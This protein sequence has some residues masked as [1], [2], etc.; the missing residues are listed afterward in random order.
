VFYHHQHV[1]AYEVIAVF[2]VMMAVIR[3]AQLSKDIKWIV[4][5]LKHSLLF[6][7][8]ALTFSAMAEMKVSTQ[9][10]MHNYKWKHRLLITTVTSDTELNQLQD[11]V[12]YHNRDIN[13]RKII[14]VVHLQN[15]TYI[16]DA[17]APDTSSKKLAS[18][19]LSKEAITLLCE[20][21]GM[22]MLVGLDGGIKSR[23]TADTFTLEQVFNEIDLMPIRR[24]E[25]QVKFK[26]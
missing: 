8:I 18:D 15:K 19:L 3:I 17:S 1:A 9:Q 21:Q 25:I 13:A 4:T 26:G 23:Y 5:Y 16:I 24:L 22:V 10:S 14:V 2:L 6:L 7:A 20:N 11:E 12:Q